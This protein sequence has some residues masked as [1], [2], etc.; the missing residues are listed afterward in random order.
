M[1]VATLTN[2]A[3]TAILIVSA[4]QNT[5]SGDMVRNS[6]QLNQEI[7]PCEIDSMAIL[8]SCDFAAGVSRWGQQAK[9]SV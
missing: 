3:V 9:N 5:S 8:R 6:A 2:R 4:S 1:M 7:T